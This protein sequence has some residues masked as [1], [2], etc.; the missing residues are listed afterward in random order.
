MDLILTP[1]TLALAI[2]TG[3][4]PAILRTRLEA[5]A[6][7]P[8]PIERQLT[9]ASTVLGRA[10][11]VEAAGFIWIDDPE[12]RRMLSTRPSTADLFVN[13]SPPSGLLVAAGVDLD[14]LSRRCRTLGVEILQGGEVHY[15]RSTPPSRRGRKTEQP[16]SSTGAVSSVRADTTRRRRSVI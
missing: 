2:G 15:A 11:F 13:P 4:D 16:P 1:R 9:Q 14:K 6:T 7:L 3:I 10:E 12:V 8:D 5:I